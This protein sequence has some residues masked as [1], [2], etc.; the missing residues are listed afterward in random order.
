MTTVVEERVNYRK[1]SG[2]L[3]DYALW[4]ADF[5]AA[6][7]LKGYSYII[8]QKKYPAQLSTKED[9]DNYK[10]DNPKLYAYLRLA[11]D[12][13]SANNMHLKVRGDGLK[14]WF[15]LKSM[16]E[17]EDDMKVANI[18]HKLYNT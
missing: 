11:V 9:Q 14:A 12:A 17:R 2:K 13:N 7:L 3:E 18:R 8:E 1:F 16:Y 10:K 6:M 15:L 4:K 5:E